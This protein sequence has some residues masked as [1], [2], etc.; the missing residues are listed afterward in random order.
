MKMI[1]S[2]LLI[3][4]TIMLGSVACAEGQGMNGV[5][6]EI[7]KD[8]ERLVGLFK[9]VH[10]DP[11]LSFMEVNT[12]A[13][14][15]T[16]L[17]KLG[18]QTI[19]KIGKTGVVGIMKNGEGPVVMYRA[20][21]DA[22]P[23]KETVDIPYASKKMSKFDDGVEVPVM[24]ACG[25][26]AHVVWMLGV[27]KVMADNK[28]KWKGTLV[29]VAQPAEEVG[30]G[31]QA[32]VHDD[33]YN[34]GVP[35]PDYLFGMHTAPFPVGTFLSEPG[36]RMAGTDQIDVTF[37]GV[38]G[39]GSSPH[40]A[41]DPVIMTAT[42][43]NS[44]Q[45]IVSRGIDPQRAAV[46]TVGSVQAGE[47]NN[48]IPSSSLLKINLRWFE[49]KDRQL[50]IS[51]IQRINE[52]IAY[53]YNLDKSL[54]PTMVKKGWAA[55][56]VND[57]QLTGIVNTGLQS[58]FPEAKNILGTPAVMGSEDF[59]HLV[60]ENPNYSYTFMLVGI[61]DPVRYNDAAKAGLQFPYAPHNSNFVVDLRAIPY[62]VKLASV[63]LFSIFQN[64]NN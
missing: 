32:M 57:S 48:V 51:G 41:K 30:E 40:L 37:Y 46:I 18:Y 10:S 56:V 2:L 45:S 33:M 44:Y 12:A 8:G 39:H 58:H 38:G 24:H 17:Q 27:A 60:L 11:E 28:D 3:Y 23:V 43:I 19:T 31:A 22:L 34:R 54:Y 29:L 4:V 20:D 25:H 47:S 35:V 5:F 53:S 64:K 16:E 63:S 50:M 55:P 13:L 26:D 36:V 61:A 1:V 6:G 49:E 42:A 9:K 59:H 21:M 14:V 15:D 52:G 62:G 7:D